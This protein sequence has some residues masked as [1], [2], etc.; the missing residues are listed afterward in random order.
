MIEIL[1]PGPANTRRARVS[2]RQVYGK[3]GVQ[4]YWIVD[5]ENRAI[6]VYQLQEGI[7][8]LTDTFWE[9]DML[10]SSILPSFVSPTSDIFRI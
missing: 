8:D 4:E 2:K 9:H 10:A 6:E 5:P 1:S 3:H 7:L